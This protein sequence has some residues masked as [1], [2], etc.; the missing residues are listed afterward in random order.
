MENLNINIVEPKPEEWEVLKNLKIE[1]LDQDPLAF[2]DPEEGRAKYLARTEE[3]WRSNLEGKGSSGRK[4]F[5]F[6][7]SEDNYLG[8]VSAS[9]KDS[10]AT[11]QHMYVNKEYRGQKIGKEL[12]KA[13]ISKLKADKGVSKTELQ[14]LTTQEAAINLYH[15][16]GFKDVRIIKNSAKR[17]GILYDEIEMEL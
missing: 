14:V 10:V 6:A 12:L 16:L 3:E 17:D 7:K 13:L 15:S 2:E 5:L 1:S 4:V 8:M 9:I 11:I